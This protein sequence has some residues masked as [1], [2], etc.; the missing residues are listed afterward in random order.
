[1]DILNFLG[2]VKAP[3]GIWASIINWLDGGIASYALV[4]ILLTLIIKLVMVPFDF[5]NRFVTKKN[6]MMMAKIQPELNKINKTYANNPNVKNQKTAELYK[7]HNY[8]VY[9]TCIGMLVYMVLSMVIFFTLFN[10]LRGMS[11]YKI[12]QEFETLSATYNETYNAYYGSY[13]T[14]KANDVALLEITA[15]EYAKAKAEESVVNKYSEI[16]QGFLWIKSIWRAD[17][18]QSVTLSYKDYISTIKQFSDTKDEAVIK[19]EI[20]QENYEKVMTP[21]QNANSGWNGYFLLAIINAVLSVLSMY[22]TELVAKKRAKKKGV[23]HVNT[24]NKVMMFVM[25][26]IL[27]IFTIFYNSAFGIYIVAGSLFSTI[28]SPL[29][30]WTVDC[31]MDKR[32]EKKQSKKP[33]YSR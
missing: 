25:P 30:S 5:Y 31:I 14:D 18:Y 2:A 8:N 6:S 32:E 29:I 9:G 7:K 27:A 15:E 24:T 19:Q 20:T 13:E 12:S 11:A 10:T 16:K 4:I 1:M 21:I 33:N 28:T 23:Q 22:L 3:T 26:V 17:T